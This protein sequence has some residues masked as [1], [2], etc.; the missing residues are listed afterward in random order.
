MD[1]PAPAQSQDF[2]SPKEVAG[3]NASAQ[4]FIER[5]GRLQTMQGQPDMGFD[6]GSASPGQMINKFYDQ[7]SERLPGDTKEQYERG[8]FNPKGSLMMLDRVNR[9]QKQLGREKQSMREMSYPAFWEMIQTDFKTPYQA[10]Q[11][12]FGYRGQ[13]GPSPMMDFLGGVMG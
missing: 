13:E 8:G 1:S 6:S 11:G 5:M 4:A 10:P 2:R 3:A 12:E 7:E 9:G